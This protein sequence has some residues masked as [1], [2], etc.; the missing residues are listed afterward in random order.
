MHHF[1]IL[2]NRLNLDFSQD[3]KKT[4]QDF[5]HTANPIESQNPYSIQRDSK[6]IVQQWKKT[7]SASE[8]D[9]IRTIVEDVSAAYYSDEDW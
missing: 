2:F 4:V 6:A 1:Q 3:I 9:K 5:S 7:L 8:I